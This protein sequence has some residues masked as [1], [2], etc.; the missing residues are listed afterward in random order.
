MARSKL[1][2]LARVI[3]K[4]R[5]WRLAPD[6][7]MLYPMDTDKKCWVDGVLVRKKGLGF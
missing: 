7:S 1:A 4:E 3:H 6:F 2:D 5:F